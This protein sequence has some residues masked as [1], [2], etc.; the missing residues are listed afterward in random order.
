MLVP[1]S[2]PGENAILFAFERLCSQ[3]LEETVDSFS[4]G[5]PSLSIPTFF[6][7]QEEER[8][9]LAR[10]L[11]QGPGQILANTLVELDNCLLLIESEP[12]TAATGISVLREEIRSSLDQLQA[13]VAELQ[14][15]LL[16]EMGLG[17][18]LREYVD[19]F[20]QRNEIQ[21]DCVGCD[22]M[23]ERL[24]MTMETAMFRIVQ[25]ALA[26]ILAHSGAT[27]VSV[28]IGSDSNQ[29][30]LEVR[31]NGRGFVT[32]NGTGGKRRQLGLVGMYDR[33]KLIGGQLQIYSEARKGTRVVL[34]V[35][36]H[37]HEEQPAASGGQ[38]QDGQQIQSGRKKIRPAVGGEAGSG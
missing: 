20:G 19:A 6:Q 28:H 32:N 27:K 24:P 12:A 26:N 15:P 9:R 34:T 1:L 14:P 13:L 31:D 35:P 29:V 30:L 8:Y 5:A 10:A 17:P 23:S 4:I 21:V 3:R 33:A 11:T 7:L 38:S 2:T 18:S 25:E 37:M 36:Y 16:A 22:T